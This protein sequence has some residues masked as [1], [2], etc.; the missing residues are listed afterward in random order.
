VGGLAL[1]HPADVV[2]MSRPHPKE[3]EEIIAEREGV[4]MVVARRP[5]VPTAAE[6]IAWL[7]SASSEEATAIEDE[8]FDGLRVV[9]GDE[10]LEA[11]GVEGREGGL[12]VL[13]RRGTDQAEMGR[14]LFASLVMPLA[15]NAA[16]GD[17][18]R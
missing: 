11:Y 2:V 4:E 1:E 3:G 16:R 13:V 8:Q 6:A 7:S 15:L 18:A 10:V 9:S 17:G 12:A 5:E 14:R